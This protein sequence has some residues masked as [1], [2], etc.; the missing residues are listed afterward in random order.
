MI[1]NCRSQLSDPAIN[2]LYPI[3][4]RWIRIRAYRQQMAVKT[5]ALQSVY[6]Y[7]LAVAVEFPPGFRG[8]FFCAAAQE[9]WPKTQRSATIGSCLETFANRD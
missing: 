8:G 9:K 2:F 6:A 3:G 1:I 7:S 4:N 5:N